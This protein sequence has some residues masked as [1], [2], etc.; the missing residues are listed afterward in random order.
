MIAALTLNSDIKVIDAGRQAYALGQGLYI[1]EHGHVVI[2]PHCH[3]GW[4][5][6]AVKIKS[7]T[8]ATLEAMSCAA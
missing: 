5:K 3:P 6:I 2:A 7:P 1:T 8:R 4:T